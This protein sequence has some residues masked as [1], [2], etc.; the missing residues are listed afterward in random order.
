MQRLRAIILFIVS[1]FFLT[2]CFS[3]AEDKALTD[4]IK[5]TVEEASRVDGIISID[6]SSNLTAMDESEKQAIYESLNEIIMDT[7]SVNEIA[8]YSMV[9]EL[10]SEES[11]IDFLKSTD[12]EVKI[13]YLGFNECPYCVA[14]SPKL[15]KIAEEL[16][17]DIYFY[18][19][20]ARADD[21]NFAVAMA[22][23]D[24][25][26]VPHAFIVEKAKPIQA[27]NH[28]SSMEAIEAFVTYAKSL[29]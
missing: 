3:N 13:I 25:S 28:E 21:N 17:V 9:T 29:Q 27:I 8:S 24:V 26:T 14:F 1:V 23:Y 18:N 19:T 16:A 10:D 2:G 7:Q 11:Y 15:N 12:D 4:T 5:E 22:N 6:E 20:Q